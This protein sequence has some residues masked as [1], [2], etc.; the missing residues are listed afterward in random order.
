MLFIKAAKLFV[1]L[2]TISDRHILHIFGYHS[3]Y[4]KTVR[5]KKKKTLF[6]HTITL[7]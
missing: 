7:L 1:C 5:H 6:A 4:T 3:V 2:Q